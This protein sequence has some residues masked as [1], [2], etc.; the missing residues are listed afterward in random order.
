MS[1]KLHQD[2][3]WLESQ[4]SEGK[5]SKQIADENNISYKL[6]EIYLRQHG[7]PFTPKKSENG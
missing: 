2:K 6:V 1:V 4:I 3:N 7:I 5:T